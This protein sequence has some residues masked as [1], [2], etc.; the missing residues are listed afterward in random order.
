MTTKTTTIHFNS[1]HEQKCYEDGLKIVAAK[2]AAARK[3][4]PT[5]EQISDHHIKVGNEIIARK[6]GSRVALKTFGVASKRLV[7]SPT[8]RIDA[9]AEA[10]ADRAFKSLTA[11]PAPKAATPATS[12][13][14]SRY[15]AGRTVKFL[16]S[17]TGLFGSA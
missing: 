15:E 3:L 17:G 14:R 11:K 4:S 7:L 6:F 9:I 5:A 1:A 8:E 13:A 16:G 2:I 10:V 12:T